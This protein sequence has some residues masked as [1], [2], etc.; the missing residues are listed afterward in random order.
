MTVVRLELGRPGQVDRV[1]S[2]VGDEAGGLAVDL[3]ALVQALG[4]RHRAFGSVAELA[5]G[6]LLHRA[7][8]ERRSRVALAAAHLD[9]GDGGHLTAQRLDVGPRRG[10]IGDGDLVGLD[11][12]SL[13]HAGPVDPDQGGLVALAGRCLEQGLQ[14]PVLARREGLD[15]ALALDHEAYGDRLHAA[16]REA[17]ADLAADERA[18]GVAHDAVHDA[19]RLLGVDEAHVDVARRGEG[20]GDGALGDLAEGHSPGLVVGDVYGLDDVPGDGLALAVEVGG[21]VH[22]VGRRGRLAD[23]VELL[24]TVLVD[25]VLGREVVLD[26]HA[27]LALARVLG[28]VTDVAVRGQHL[29]AVAKIP[30]D[31]PRLGRRLDDH[32]V[33]RHRRG[34]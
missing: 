31:R 2:H 24:A 17:A 12:A 15:G 25:D 33:L 21:Q 14:G 29:V 22:D 9:R 10:L 16:G 4:D 6:L 7:G 27:E 19:A 1:G 11:L 13:G 18:E 3:D 5:A 28:Q 8:G 32:E 20:I 30:F 23:G 26:V 34:V